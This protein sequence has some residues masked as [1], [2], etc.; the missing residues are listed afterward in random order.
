MSESKVGGQATDLATGPEFGGDEL[1]AGR[2]L[3]SL[4]GP[5]RGV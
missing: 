5:D 3:S 2:A 4:N 1:S